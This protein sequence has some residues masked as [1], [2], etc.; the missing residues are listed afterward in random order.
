MVVAVDSRDDLTLERLAMG[1]KADMFE[2][3][4]GRKVILQN[5]R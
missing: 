3:V 2:E 4:F 1:T 5:Q